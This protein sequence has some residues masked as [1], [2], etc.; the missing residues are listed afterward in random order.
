MRYP[1]TPPLRVLCLVLVGLYALGSQCGIAAIPVTPGAA[2][3]PGFIAYDTQQDWYSIA[4]ETG[5]VYTIAIDNGSIRD[6][7]ATLFAPDGVTVL[8]NLTTVD[9]DT[10]RLLFTWSPAAAPVTA[11]LRVRGF[12]EFT[13][14]TYS[15]AVNWDYRPAPDSDQDGVPD[16][17]ETDTGNWVSY[18]NTGS[19]PHAPDSDGDF[20]NDWAETR[21][22]TDPNNPL[23]YPFATRQ[24][25]DGDGKADIAVYWPQAGQWY[26]LQSAQNTTRIVD[27]GWSDTQPVAADFDGD[28]IT[29]IAVY[30]PQGGNWYIQYSG[31]GNTIM[32][33]GWQAARPAPADYD[34]DHMADI[35]VFYDVDGSWYI[36][37][38]HTQSV[39]V[40]QWG[41]G[42][43]TTVPA[44]FDADGRADPTIFWPENGTWY[45]R[46]S[47]SQSLRTVQWGWSASIAV[48]ADYDGDHIADI[49]VYWPTVGN[50]YILRSSDQQITEINWG[51]NAAIPVPNDY[52]GDGQDDIAVF[53]PATGAWYIRQSSTGQVLVRNWGWPDTLPIGAFY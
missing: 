32:N 50:W 25:F 42:G 48:P 47:E 27:W 18:V 36:R 52:D 17:V 33:W 21:R 30:W 29:D 38:S 12:A 14:G 26:I 49:A 10:R 43:T 11:L 31:G 13:T 4:F 35:A 22:G 24:D 44:D 8:T 6:T 9:T 15:L 45:I 37:L 40:Y 2:S 41:W 16:W 7:E 23:S 3:T 1:Q 51:W 28:G 34:G 20:W 46:Q 19:D 5:I 53:D 39:A